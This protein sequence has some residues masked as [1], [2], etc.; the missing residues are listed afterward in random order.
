M[1]KA[2]IGIFLKVNKFYLKKNLFHFNTESK[3]ADG[4]PMIIDEHSCT[5]NAY[6]FMTGG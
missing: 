1:G 4:Q 3:S 5:Y 2:C 6:F